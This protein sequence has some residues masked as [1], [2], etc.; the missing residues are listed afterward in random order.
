[1][2]LS[3]AGVSASADAIA[4]ALVGRGFEFWFTAKKQLKAN[5]TPGKRGKTAQPEVQKWQ[6]E[7]KRPSHDSKP[8][9]RYPMLAVAGGGGPPVGEAQAPAGG[10]AS[11][12]EF[13]FS[14]TNKLGASNSHPRCSWSACESSRCCEILSRENHTHSI[15]DGST[16]ITV[17]MLKSTKLFGPPSAGHPLPEIRRRA[18]ESLRFKLDNNLLS[19]RFAG[20]VCTC[21]LIFP[22]GL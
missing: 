9:S 4:D 10:T 13:L 17:L 18:L 22:C 15:T 7:R 19:A 5:S 12:L 8:G 14:T 3:P 21:A 16:P 6:L 20:Q 1:M 2:T 11:A